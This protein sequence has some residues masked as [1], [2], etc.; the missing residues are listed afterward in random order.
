MEAITFQSFNL[1]F[2]SNMWIGVIFNDRD[3]GGRARAGVY[4]IWSSYETKHQELMN[5]TKMLNITSK[6]KVRTTN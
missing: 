5:M 1:L 6:F 2:L 4:D 3:W